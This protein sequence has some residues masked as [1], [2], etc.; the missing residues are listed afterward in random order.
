MEIDDIISTFV[1]KKRDER[2]KRTNQE[3]DA[4]R[5]TVTRVIQHNL[6]KDKRSL[7][8]SK[9]TAAARTTKVTQ[10][11]RR[12]QQLLKTAKNMIVQLDQT[13][14]TVLQQ[15]KEKERAFGRKKE[16]ALRGEH[17][18]TVSLSPRSRGDCS[19]EETRAAAGRP[20][21]GTLR[22]DGDLQAGSV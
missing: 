16:A 9:K 20:A 3:L 15:V 17:P 12:I 8:R 13:Q 11:E 14:K 1:A 5:S 19:E 10:A 21:K 4:A 7:K 6:A 2:Q 18:P 22:A